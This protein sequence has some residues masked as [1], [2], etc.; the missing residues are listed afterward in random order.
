MATSRRNKAKIYI[1]PEN[2][3]SFSRSA[4]R[5]GKGVQEHARAVLANPKSSKALRKKAQFAVNMKKLANK[6]KRSK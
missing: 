2:R 6:R 1:K 5:A 3:G 4:K